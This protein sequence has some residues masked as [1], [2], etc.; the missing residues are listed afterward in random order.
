MSSQEEGNGAERSDEVVV[1]VKNPRR[2]HEN[3][4]T[5]R[6]FQ[7]ETLGQLKNRLH[8]SYP[9]N[10][11]PDTVTVSGACRARPGRGPHPPH[12]VLFLRTFRHSSL[13][14]HSFMD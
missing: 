4:F 10:P 8:A 1:V 6:L 11:T 2:S 12:P 7:S 5:V 13:K 3:P 14:R 9:G